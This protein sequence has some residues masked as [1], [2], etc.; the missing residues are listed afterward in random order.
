MTMQSNGRH[1]N[2]RSFEG[3]TGHLILASKG[4]A[5][6]QI[7]KKPERPISVWV[8]ILLLPGPL[9]QF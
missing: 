5:F 1:L 3:Y 7:Y 6:L 4:K 8:W 2:L 9:N